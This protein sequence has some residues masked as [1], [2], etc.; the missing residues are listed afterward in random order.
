M[1]TWLFY[2]H[3]TVYIAFKGKILSKSNATLGSIDLIPSVHRPKPTVFITL[4]Q[5][6][7]RNQSESSG[8]TWK[9]PTLSNNPLKRRNNDSNNNNNNRNANNNNTGIYEP[10]DFSRIQNNQNQR[11]NNE[12]DT[13]QQNENMTNERSNIA[14]EE[15]EN[16]EKM[17]RL[18][19]DGAESNP[20]KGRLF[21]PCLCSGTMKYI[22]IGCLNTWRAMAPND[23]SY[24]RCDQCQYLYNVHRAEWT[25]ILEDKRTIYT[26]SAILLLIAIVIVGLLTFKLPIANYVWDL[27]EWHPKYLVT[28]KEHYLRQEEYFIKLNE[29]IQDGKELDKSEQRW[30]DDAWDIIYFCEDHCNSWLPWKECPRNCVMNEI[31]YSF[32]LFCFVAILPMLVVF[33][34]GYKRFLLNE[35]D[36]CVYV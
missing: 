7:K 3:R 13:S 23:R 33:V 22:H 5:N 15:N 10:I 24:Y 21:R 6:Q 30:I 28:S 26:I 31:S 1:I 32:V 36:L 9:P 17:C 27:I 20:L 4:K 29:Y 8:Q 16:E 12:T 35:I 18:C 34:Q 14:A 2:S 19:F 11:N 25:R